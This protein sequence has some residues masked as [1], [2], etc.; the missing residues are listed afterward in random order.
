MLSQFK[1]KIED[2]ERFSPENCPTVVS[3]LHALQEGIA[4][5][6][7]YNKVDII[8]SYLKNHSIKIDLINSNPRVTEKMTSGSFAVSHI[9]AYFDG[10]KSNQSFLLDFEH[11]IE[12]QFQKM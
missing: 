6:P 10:C 9:E 4:L 8:I 11:F 3:Q 12:R 5:L 2:G 7:E 1:Y